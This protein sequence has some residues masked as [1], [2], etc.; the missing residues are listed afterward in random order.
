MSCVPEHGLGTRVARPYAMRQPLL[1]WAAVIVFSINC[2]QMTETTHKKRGSH[3]QVVYLG[4]YPL[5]VGLQKFHSGLYPSHNLFGLVELPSLGISTAVAEHS[6]SKLL[7]RIAQRMGLGSSIATQIAALR[8]ARRGDI[9]FSVCLPSSGLLA[10]LKRL[11]LL[12]NP[13]VTL[14]HHPAMASRVQRFILGGNDRLFF[15]SQN[16]LNSCRRVHGLEEVPLAV[17]PWGP[18]QDFFIPTPLPDGPLHVVAA[19]KSSRDYLTLVD[20][21]RQVDVR[22]T[23]VCPRDRFPQI[24]LPANVRLIGGSGGAQPLEERELTDLYQSAHVIA[25]P[26]A[27][28]EVM[29]GLTSLLDALAIHRPVIITRNPNIDIDVEAEHVGWWAEPDDVQS[30]VVALNE[31]ARDRE[32]LHSMA[33]NC[34]RLCGSRNMQTVAAFLKLELDAMTVAS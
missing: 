21:A 7:D 3:L 33:A 34:G 32:R 12:R 20:A 30:W 16:G 4:D 14:V 9:L 2:G 15:L 1:V 8:R 5:D 24:T 25:V 28:I 13:L 31:A 23:I 6:T 11:G 27:R 29:A 19:G 18:Q 26:L 22:V 10:V 17:L